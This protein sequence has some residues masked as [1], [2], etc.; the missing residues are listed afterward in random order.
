[1]P[2]Y[3]D[4]TVIKAMIDLEIDEESEY[5]FEDAALIAKAAIKVLRSMLSTRSI[6]EGGFQIQLAVQERIADLQ[7]EHGILVVDKTAPTVRGRNVW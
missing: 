5:D 4:N 6:T 3:S 2:N 7:N 1:L